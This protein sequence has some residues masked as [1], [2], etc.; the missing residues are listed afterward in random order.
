MKLCFLPEISIFKIVTVNPHP[1]LMDLVGH[2]CALSKKALLSIHECSE[3]NSEVINVFS[4]VALLGNNASHKCIVKK[5]GAYT[6]ARLR[7]IQN[8][9]N[10]SV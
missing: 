8:H 3:I 4:K 9:H 1:H 5:I 2:V 7:H 6:R 10:K